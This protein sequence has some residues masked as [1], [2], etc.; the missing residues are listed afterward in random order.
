MGLGRKIGKL[1]LVT[2][3]GAD[4][5]GKGMD[6]VFGENRTRPGDGF[7]QDRT[8]DRAAEF[9]RKAKD[10]DKAG[11]LMDK[12]KDRDLFSSKSEKRKEKRDFF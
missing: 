8:R 6:K 5:V 11:G 1:A 10:G 7:S 3:R 12:N 4:K 9:T 2:V